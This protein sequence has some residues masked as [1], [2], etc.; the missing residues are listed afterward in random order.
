MSILQLE[1]ERRQQEIQNQLHS[2]LFSDLNEKI[3]YHREIQ[4][5]QVLEQRPVF[6]RLRKHDMLPSDAT[7]QRFHNRT[8]NGYRIV[9]AIKGEDGTPGVLFT[10]H[11]RTS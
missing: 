10:L 1:E 6:V 2:D 11:K 7:L 8:C 5:L 4:T 3:N 9:T